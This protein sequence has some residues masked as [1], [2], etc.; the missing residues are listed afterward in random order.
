[1]NTNHKTSHS[2]SRVERLKFRDDSNVV[3]CNSQIMELEFVFIRVHSW[4]LLLLVHDLVGDCLDKGFGVL[5]YLAV[6]RGW[7]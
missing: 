7:R 2:H 3:F 4:F 1:M 5:I 6:S